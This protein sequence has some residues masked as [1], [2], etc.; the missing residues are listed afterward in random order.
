VET[1]GS[2]RQEG[3]GCEVFLEVL[4]EFLQ[5]FGFRSEW[6]EIGSMP[7]KSFVVTI[8][9]AKMMPRSLE[10]YCAARMPKFEA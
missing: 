7:K 6:G 9:M 8:L 4:L 5:G 3:P 1:G 10:I 2:A